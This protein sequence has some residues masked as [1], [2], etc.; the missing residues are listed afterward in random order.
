MSEA[1]FARIE[2]RLAAGV[3]RRLS[4]AQLQ[5]GVAQVGVIHDREFIEAMP[6]YAG[7]V[8]ASQ[9]V[10]AMLSTDVAAHAIA[11]GTEVQ[12]PPGGP[13]FTV[14]SVRPDSGGLTVLVLQEPD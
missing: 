10:C 11:A 1:P 2:A 3:M 8:D 6:G 4:N 7:G 9:P 12:L 13:E 5:V 14:R